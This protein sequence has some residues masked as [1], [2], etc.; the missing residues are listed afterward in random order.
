MY[1]P[2][3]ATHNQEHVKF[4]RSCGADI[5]LVPDAV[6][7]NLAEKLAAAEANP[8]FADKV[9]R[10]KK[11]PTIEKGIKTLFMGAA[12]A[13]IA[14]IISTSV[15]GGRGWWF[16]LLIPAFAMLGDGVGTIIRVRQ[17]QNRLAPPPYAP[18]PTAF[19]QTRGE[20]A[21]LPPRGAADELFQQPSS[22]TEGTTRHLGVPVERSSKD[23]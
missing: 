1:C 12:F 15:P 17:E 21:T 2:R 18:A 6:H 7:G 13:L 9:K 19:P 3:C 20:A 16:W 23:A 10:A 11:P 4:C 14:V 8:N 5:S 22:V